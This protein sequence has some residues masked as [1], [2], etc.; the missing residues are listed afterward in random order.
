MQTTEVKELERSGNEAVKQLRQAKHS[1]GLPFMINSKGL[2][3][4][5][6]YLEYP[7]GKMV[8]VTLK[9]PEDRDYTLIR[10]LSALERTEILANFLLR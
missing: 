9:S 3:P 10:E 1:K 8:I 2:P 4:N 7:G 6:C 5:Q